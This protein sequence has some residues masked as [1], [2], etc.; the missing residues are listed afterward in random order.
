MK[1]KEGRYRVQKE[2]LDAEIEA[3]HDLKNVM[4]D[5]LQLKAKKWWSLEAYS[6]HYKEC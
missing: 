4:H 3:K 2:V 6:D 1:F 5:S